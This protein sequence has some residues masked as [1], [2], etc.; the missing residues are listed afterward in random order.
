MTAWPFVRQLTELLQPLSTARFDQLRFGYVRLPLSERISQF[1]FK[2]VET[3]AALV[4]L[5]DQFKNVDVA[6]K[7]I[8]EDPTENIRARLNLNGKSNMVDSFDPVSFCG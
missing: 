2:D 5:R 4:E 8:T 1:R 7:W 6:F 3:L